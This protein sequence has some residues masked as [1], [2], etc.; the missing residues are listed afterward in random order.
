MRQVIERDNGKLTIVS[1][2]HWRFIEYGYELRDYEK[3]R[4]EFDFLDDESFDV[5]S[6]VWY[7]GVYHYLG[8]FLRAPISC[9]KPVFPGWEGYESDSYFSGNVINFSDDG[10]SVQIGW[11]YC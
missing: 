7:K 9:G 3:Q 4:K 10:E 6:F 5:S 1:N 11:Y 8:D 2:K